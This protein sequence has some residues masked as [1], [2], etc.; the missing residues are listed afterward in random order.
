MKVIILTFAEVLAFSKNTG[1]GIEY[2]KL[3]HNL[4]FPVSGKYADCGYQVSDLESYESQMISSTNYFHRY[5]SFGISSKKQNDTCPKQKCFGK[6]KD[7]TL[8][9]FESNI[10]EYF[11]NFDTKLKTQPRTTESP[12]SSEILSLSE[13]ANILYLKQTKTDCKYSVSETISVTKLS[14]YKWTTKFKISAESCVPKIC[15]AKIFYR[16]CFCWIN[17]LLKV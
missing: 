3:I 12:I 7:K 14:Y 6:V 2:A 10:E 17:F 1:K 9:Y 15:E 11:C 4:K 16:V 8:D 5:V 13:I